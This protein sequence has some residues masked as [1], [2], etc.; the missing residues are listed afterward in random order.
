LVRT[1]SSRPAR[2]VS[3][4][5]IASVMVLPVQSHIH[6]H[7]VMRPSIWTPWHSRLRD[8][9]APPRAGNRASSLHRAVRSMPSETTKPMS[10]CWRSNA[11]HWADWAR[12]A[13][14]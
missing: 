7:Q 14:A 2:I 10:R 8:L 11:R 6:R 13:W 3:M 5:V 12:Q 1:W 4:S 9:R